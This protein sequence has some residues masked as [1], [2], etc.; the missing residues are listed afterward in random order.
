MKN[1][2]KK[3][4]ALI[5]AA[6]MTLSLSA[7]GNTA[8]SAASGSASA[9]GSSDK[10]KI[11]ILQY[12][13]HPSLDNCYQGIVEGLK[14]AGFVDGE[15]CTI[16]YQNGQGEAETN[17]LVANNFVS[18]KYDIIIPIATPAAMSAYSVAKNANIP[19]VFTAVSDPVSAG[20]VQSLDAPNSGATGTSDSLNLEGQ[21]KM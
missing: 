4:F 21:M 2:M 3:A 10:V 16:D 5:M 1:T 15:N 6:A 7:C 20:L 19:V 11:G 9:A 17:N 8:G 13:P 18:G 14:E 12:A